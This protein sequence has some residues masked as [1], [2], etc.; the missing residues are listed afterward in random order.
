MRI[1]FDSKDLSYKD[2]FG[3]LTP[4]QECTFNIRIPASVGTT[5]V[6]C[7][8]LWEDGSFAYEFPMTYAMKKDAY[9]RFR[10]KI[11]LPQTGLYFYYDNFVPMWGAWGFAYTS[12]WNIYPVIV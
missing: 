1:L 6:N 4:G 8:F 12:Q 7:I 2:P 9:E 10:C 3:T 11:S 5:A